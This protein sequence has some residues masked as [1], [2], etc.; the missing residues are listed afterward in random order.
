MAN[1][2]A[3]A[4]VVKLIGVDKNVMAMIQRVQGGFHGLKKTVMDSVVTFA[5]AKVAFQSIIAPFSKMFSV[6]S[7]FEMEMSK[8]KA[9]T[10]S[11]S[12]EIKKL[13]DQ[14]K[15]LGKT[16][17]FTTSQVANAQMFLGMAGFDAE[18][19]EAA[20]PNVLNLALAG[21]LDIGEAADIATNISTPFNIAAK[22]LNHV[23][24]VLA[25]AAVSSN[26]NIQEMGQA[27]KY[28][29][30]AAANA[31]QSIEECG[32]AIA[33]LANNGIKAD[34]AGTSLRMM[35]IKLADAGIQKK[36]KEQFNIDVTDVTGK[37]KPLLSVLEELK[38]ATSNMGQTAQMSAFYDIFEQRAGT[39]AIVLGKAGDAV[40]NFRA[41]MYNA[42]GTTD[43]IAKTMSDNIKGDWI[44]LVSALEGVQIAIGE[45]FNELSRD[46]LQDLTE[47]TRG[48]IEFINENHD[49]IASLASMTVFA[50]K[51]G[52]VLAAIYV[53]RKFLVGIAGTEKS[54]YASIIPQRQAETAAIV[55]QNQTIAANTAATQ[56]NI[57]AKRAA[58]IAE[59]KLAKASIAKQLGNV[60]TNITGLTAQKAGLVG[61]L[62]GVTAQKGDWQKELQ[63]AQ[64]KAI[65]GSAAAQTE[66]ALI[67]KEINALKL[68][69]AT[70]NQKL[71]ATST[72]LTAAEAKRAALT[73]ASATANYTMANKLNAITMSQIAV[74]NAATTAIVRKTVAERASA[75][76]TG[77]L[78]KVTVGLKAIWAALTASMMANP[79]MWIAGAVAGIAALAYQLTV[80]REKQAELHDEMNKTREKGDVTRSTDAKK[81]ERLKQLSNA[82]KLSNIETKEAETLTKDL[83]SR[84]GD[85]G[86]TI[87]ETSGKI[88]LAADA[89]KRFMEAMNA[90]SLRELQDELEEGQKN[91]KNLQEQADKTSWYWRSVYANV[92][93]GYVD[94]GEDVQKRLG[95]QMEEQMKKNNEIRKKMIRLNGGENALDVAKDPTALLDEKIAG[96]VE[97]DQEKK[98]KEAEKNLENIRN[99]L[100]RE[101]RSSLEN[102]IA[103]LKKRNEEYKKYLQLLLDAENAKPEGERDQNKIGELWAEMQEAEN[104]FGEGMNRLLEKT[105][106]KV[107]DPETQLKSQ[108]EA[109]IVAAMRKRDT[110]VESGDKKA[111]EAAQ[112]ELETLKK[113]HADTQ[114]KNIKTNLD[115]AVADLDKAKEEYQKA[116]TS[117]EKILAAQKLKE[118]QEKAGTFSSAYEGMSDK[119]FNEKMDEINER[120]KEK[121]E[122]DHYSNNGKTGTFNAA[123]M[124]SVQGNFMEDALKSQLKLQL[125]GNGLLEK[126]YN[127]LEGTGRFA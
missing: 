120:E 42:A 33:I 103:D 24:D 39:S 107:F 89:M 88:N 22:N 78:V 74:T 54:L 127:E 86:A 4:L 32:A 27:F 99:Q 59:A 73:K 123:E 34:M 41:K 109:E 7:S 91:F 69:E 45:V 118:A 63:A 35:M 110:A 14:A 64:V 30:P 80:A 113:Q 87:D 66:V 116:T 13:R 2:E 67:Q 1:S 55:S 62:A 36:L 71:T 92:T 84:Y 93:V 119:Q 11:T 108:Q 19:I 121:E 15:L 58:I 23:N 8:V 94:T 6:F 85:F 56:A 52:A 9:I 75:V 12:E 100:E 21:N 104:A 29:A 16:T 26:T 43:E 111:M 97:D 47:L 96:G 3:G 37:M 51:V 106:E 77:V 90:N 70:I 68:Q 114:I 122:T 98:L 95:E 115:T 57:A 28:A 79:M 48:L 101:R 49:F 83:E 17:F 102:E 61:Q 117:E 53:A 112:K 38:E 81:F 125:N 10:K 124:T 65:R 18:K 72:Q 60:N 31:G 25:K 126:I 76:A 5:A 46:T 44:A 40:Q 82:Q 50:A 105:R 20:L